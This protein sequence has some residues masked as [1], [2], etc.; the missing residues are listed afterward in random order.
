MALFGSTKMVYWKIE[1]SGIDVTDLLL[2]F[3]KSIEITDSIISPKNKG[4]KLDVPSKAKISISS[5]DYIEDFF[6]EGMEI[7]IWMGYDR[8]I[9]PLVFSGTIRMLPDGS[10]S[11][12]L[13]YTVKAYGDGTELA[14]K[15]R[16]RLYLSTVKSDIISQIA[17][18]NGYIPCIDVK[19][20]Q[21][22][23]VKYMPF[24]RKMTDLEFLHKCA[25]DWRCVFWFKQGTLAKTLYFVDAEKAHRIGDDG[26]PR[27]GFG[28]TPSEYSLG[29]RTDK[30][31]CNVES[32]NWTHTPPGSASISSPFV[33]G[34][35]EDGEV[36]GIFQRRIFIKGQ[37]WKM[38]KE[39]IAEAKNDMTKLKKAFGVVFK[40]QFSLEAYQGISEY[41]RPE[42]YTEST[43]RD[44][45]P[46]HKEL[47]FD[48]SINLNVGDPYLKPPRNAFLWGGTL[49][50]RADGADLPAWL[51]RNS[52]W[53]G[54]PA[55]LKINETILSYSGGRLKSNLKCSMGDTG[56]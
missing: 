17:V 27:F 26:T 7:S 5:K 11:E 53:S 45:P 22:I 2:K 41:W 40:A 13:H 16:N 36:T 47:G 32:V 6:V 56:V 52:V 43:S 37:Y 20:Y 28:F 8:L 10:A 25:Y 55:K 35:T 51:F 12:M 50:P 42:K 54:G 33:G 44:V 24:Q 31:E 3:V 9:N 14:M 1:L 29:Y 34:A 15:E 38:K 39:F 30:V 23:P 4:K 21:P 49:S 48:I 46:S 18:V 19:D